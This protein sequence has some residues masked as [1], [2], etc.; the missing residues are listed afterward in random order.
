MNLI[1]ISVHTKKVK[2]DPH[3]HIQKNIL[4]CST[5]INYINS[6]SPYNHPRASASSTYT[7]SP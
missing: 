6:L 1:L 2:K 7:M 4:M 5:Y 3:H